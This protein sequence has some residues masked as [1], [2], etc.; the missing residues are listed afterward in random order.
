ML[1][2][3]CRHTHK[4]TNPPGRVQESLRCT[5]KRHA[6]S[7]Q[8]SCQHF[9]CPQTR[10][11]RPRRCP[12]HFILAC[13]FMRQL[14]RSSVVSVRKVWIGLA[15]ISKHTGARSY[16]FFLSVDHLYFSQKRDTDIFPP[17]VSRLF[18]SSLVPS[19]PTSFK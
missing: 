15:F 9:T 6:K 12:S 14:G 16:L 8:I 5:S 11:K 17:P 3:F 10:E 4:R 1:I 18:V 13:T 7:R 19:T 2:R